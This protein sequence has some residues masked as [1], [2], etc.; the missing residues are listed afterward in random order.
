MESDYSNTYDILQQLKKVYPNE[1]P[2]DLIGEIEL[3][4]LKGQQ[5]V[6]RSIEEGLALQEIRNQG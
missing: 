6:I 4:K 2:K 5:D 1:L 3:A